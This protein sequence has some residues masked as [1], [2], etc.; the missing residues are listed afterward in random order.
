VL[1]FDLG[2][3]GALLMYGGRHVFDPNDPQIA[4]IAREWD[5]F[6]PDVAY[7]E[8]GNPP[9]DIVLSSAVQRAGEAGLVR[10]LAAR[11]QVPVATFEP[12]D[13]DEIRFLLKRYSPEQ[14]K[15]FIVLRSY[16]T[17][18]K[19]KQDETSE[20]Y[21]SRVLLSPMWEQAGIA[22]PV[23]KLEEFREAC[24]RL[25]PD[26]DDWREIPIEWFDPAAE[27]HF[28][29]DAANESGGVRDRHIFQVLTDRARRGDRVFAVI[30]ASHVPVQE[31]A[32]VATLGPPTR[33]RNGPATT[34]SPR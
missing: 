18:R 9:T 29:N 17:F 8:G 16:L 11:D 3:R 32:L 15:V 12:K 24:K 20:Q 14:V 22:E 23:R 19:S 21:I 1:E 26:L 13:V 4:D 25:F 10:Y 30:G 2:G 6:K 34:T 33:K 31:P 5:R 27:G 7:N 28:T